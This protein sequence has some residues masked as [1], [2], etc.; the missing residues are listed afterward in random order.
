MSLFLTKYFS[1]QIKS[2]SRVLI[3]LWSYEYP[4]LKLL[5]IRNVTLFI[6]SMNTQCHREQ[7]A[8]FSKNRA[9]NAF[10]F[11]LNFY[12]ISN[13]L[14]KRKTLVTKYQDMKLKNLE[15]TQSFQSNIES[16]ADIFKRQD[17]YIYA[18][19]YK[20]FLKFLVICII[21]YLIHKVYRNS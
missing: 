8:S 11:C 10:F 5:L 17:M 20:V 1:I 3:R 21:Y 13:Y 19:F 2:K 7:W 9:E 18:R 6:G 16:C 15:L 4:E 12:V 14:N